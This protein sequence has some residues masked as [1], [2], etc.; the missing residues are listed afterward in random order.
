MIKFGKAGHNPGVHGAVLSDALASRFSVQIQV[1]TFSG[2]IFVRYDV[3]G[4]HEGPR[5]TGH[6]ATANRRPLRRDVHDDNPP[7]RL[8]VEARGWHQHEDRPIR[9]VALGTGHGRY[10]PTT[11]TKAAIR[12]IVPDY[13]TPVWPLTRCNS[14]ADGWDEAS[15]VGRARVAVAAVAHHANVRRLCHDRL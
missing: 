11:A 2:P 6:V 14:G 3:L 4:Q 7:T 10:N 8:K 15:V 9:P 5:T 13:R 1:S 12:G